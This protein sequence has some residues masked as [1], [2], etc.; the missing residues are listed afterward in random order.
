MIQTVRVALLFTYLWNN[1]YLSSEY[2]SM[3]AKPLHPLVQWAQRESCLYLTVEIDKV[4][5][6]N[7][8]PK[9]LHVK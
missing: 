7:V 1:I 8:T 6:L 4:E 3:A 5:Q 9:D 2:H